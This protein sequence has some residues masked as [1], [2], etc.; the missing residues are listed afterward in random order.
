MSVPPWAD[1]LIALYESGACSQ[2]VLSGNVSDRVLLPP[3][4]GRRIGSLDA[5]L[6]S[7]LLPGFDV[8]ASYDVGHGIR[9]EQGEAIVEE[10]P[11]AARFRRA[12]TPRRSIEAISHF[13]LY[14]ANLARLRRRSLQV[15]VVVL[16]SQLVA[17]ELAGG[18]H[19]DLNATALLMRDWSRD[20]A[21]R[22]LSL[23]T[24]LVC[25]NR[26]DLHPLLLQNPRAA[27]LE[28]PLPGAEL[29]REALV[30]LA[31]AC[32]AALPDDGPDPGYC[33]ERLVGAT[34]ASVEALVRTRDHAGTPLRAAD[35]AELKKSL[36]ERECN[37]LVEFVEPDR[38]LDDYCG[39]P[40]VV[41]WL[42]K[43]LALW[44]RGELD[45]IP[46]GYLLCGP[47]GTG[48]TFLAECLAGEADVPVVVLRNFRDRWVGSTESN[49]E[50]IFR[51]L[52]ALGRCIVFVDEADQALGARDA[53]GGDAGLSGRV[54]SM[55]AD[56]MSDT[57]NRGR[58]V[59]ILATSRPD[60]VEVDLKRP[61]RIDVRLPLFPT[62]GAREGF[63]L[64]R[65]LLRRRHLELDAQDYALLARQVP[66]GLTPGAAESLA[67][68]AYRFARAD[69]L[70][71][72]DAVQRCLTTYRPAV[73]PEVM[74]FQIELAAAEASDISL[75]PEAY[76]A[77]VE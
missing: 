64:L 30:E 6:R 48:K 2:F 4:A 8:V 65:A 50:R 61:G 11:A 49:L 14:A 28:V 33:A 72:R 58:I 19:Y 34:L 77:L 76:R 3:G 59:W 71:A 74:A 70:S 68:K 44:E 57:R 27:H 40:R 7:V 46:M 41:D 56:E 10:W 36:V 32:P 60:L 69:G 63:S 73:P 47:V 1:E 9:V 13:L 21:L 75:V 23:A 37:G 26:A 52:H 54:Y 15:A 12:D 31:G 62:A 51:L 39:Q 55:F 53:G 29:L 42:R 38:S 67:V 24:F 66:A 17:P 43:D 22:E 35:L 5:Y 18:L 25:E 16:D 45:A 20:E